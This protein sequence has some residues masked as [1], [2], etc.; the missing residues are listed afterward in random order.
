MEEKK[1]KFILKRMTG[2]KGNLSKEDSKKYTGPKLKLKRKYG[3]EK[4]KN[5]Y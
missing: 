1:K 3:K 5:S 2:E 4:E